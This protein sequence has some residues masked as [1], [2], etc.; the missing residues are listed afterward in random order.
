MA[1]DGVPVSGSNKI[2]TPIWEESPFE[3]FSGNKLRTL[4]PYNPPSLKTPGIIPSLLDEPTSITFL[5]GK[6]HLP[7]D[8]EIIVFSMTLIASLI[9]SSSKTFF[10]DKERISISPY[11]IN[12]AIFAAI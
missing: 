4:T 10:D 3:G 9:E 2:T 5:S 12:S 11:K 6:I 1:A 7:S 8:T